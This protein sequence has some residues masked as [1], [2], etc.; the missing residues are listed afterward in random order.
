MLGMKPIDFVELNKGK[1]DGWR[2]V[3][4]GEI[5]KVVSGFPFP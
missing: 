1:K 2:V 4:L 5:C 3:R